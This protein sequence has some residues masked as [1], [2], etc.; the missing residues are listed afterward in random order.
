MKLVNKISLSGFIIGIVII[1]F[2]YNT[3]NPNSYFNN[4]G[5]WLI[6][7]TIVLLSLITSVI[8][9]IYGKI[10]KK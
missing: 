8:S 10:K 3:G 4:L 7:V 1:I 2:S 9:L 5:M 6:G